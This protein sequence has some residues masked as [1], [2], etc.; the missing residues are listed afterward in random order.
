MPEEDAAAAE[1]PPRTRRTWGQ[2]LFIA[3]N[4]VM[5]GVCL[6]TAAGIAYAYSKVSGI[7]RV[8]LGQA[9]APVGSG[10]SDAPQ[11]FLIVGVDSAE[12]LDPGDPV[13]VGRPPGLRS[14]TIMVLR[15]DPRSGQAALLSLPRDLY[16]PIAGT[17]GKDRIN[18]A[19][20]GG[21]QRLIETI[22]QDF[23]IPINH[24]VEINFYAFRT[25]VDAIGGVP[26]YFANPARDV[27][28]GLD[29]PAAGCVTLDP[30]QA[31]AFARSRFY[32]ENVN[33]RWRSDPTG[34]LGRISRQQEFI[35]R[36]LRRSIEK[37]ARNPTVLN[38]LIDAAVRNVRLDPTL[39]PSNLLDL[40]RRFRDFNP[41]NLTTYSVPA[42]PTK[43]GGG[44]VL[45]LDPIRSEPIFQQF[46][47]VEGE[48]S[49]N[50]PVIVA[51]S[52]GTG[53]PDQAQQ[54]AD[55][56]RAAGFTV[57]GANVGEADR[58]DY[59]RTL[60]W[61]LPGEQAQAE[62]VAA[63]LPGGAVVEQTKLPFSTADVL[64]IT[65][66]DF[67]GVAANPVVTT[68]PQSTT[69]TAPP[70]V[71]SAPAGLPTSTTQVGTVPTTPQDVS[72]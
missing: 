65:G 27:H 25:I 8:Q 60:V 32:E 26:V 57:P 50:A 45:K 64:V 15:T 11:N 49:P 48:L 10:G 72:C 6:A 53:A 70:T 18:A 3:F 54:A 35:R 12:G 43:V 24:Y 36:V 46:R 69:T 71:T 29:V 5:I 30:V 61:Y 40:G 33:G 67:T 13:L 9:L 23:G 55:G 31:L 14:D 62:Q 41:D 51:V 17:K 16:V 34:D 4:I 7:G 42:T 63:Y 68:A 39:T 19:I 37:G 28:S 38:D 52:N 21:P 2:R 47:A 58:T 44:D 20:Q 1:P 59:E 56:L 66:K 22:K